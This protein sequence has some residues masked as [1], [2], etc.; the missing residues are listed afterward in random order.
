M[1]LDAPFILASR[2]PRRRRLLDRI[3]MA[4]EVEA[5]HA[6][7]TPPAGASPAE[8]AEALAHRKAAEIAALHPQALTLGADTIV[9]LDGEILDKPSSEADARKTLGRLSGRTH[10]VYTGIALIHPHTGRAVRTH[11]ATRVT[12]AEMDAEEIA[13]YVSSGAPM[14][15][16][17]AYG[18]QDDRGALFVRRIE[19]DYY[20][21]V[22]L[23]LH[24]FYQTM[25]THFSDLL[26]HEYLIS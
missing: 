11:E 25:K 14:D 24:R 12:F 17:G 10:V 19:G 20:N 15:K 16:A 2:S 6:D 7:E 9:V 3:G 26:S 13:A 5:S 23:P 8:I 18:I 4:F 22:G 1:K 21:V